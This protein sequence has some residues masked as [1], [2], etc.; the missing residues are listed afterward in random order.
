MSIVH[1][2][3]ISTPVSYKGLATYIRY[4]ALLIILG[5]EEAGGGAYAKL[6]LG[7]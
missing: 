2:Q 3:V 5:T 4:V 7:G 6:L 1:R